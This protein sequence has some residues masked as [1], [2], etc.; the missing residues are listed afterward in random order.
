[1]QK[2]AFASLIAALGLTLAVAVGPA[3]AQTPTGDAYGGLGGQTEGPADS[4]P[5]DSGPADVAPTDVAP[6]TETAAETE[7]GGEVV[8]VA[9]TS[10]DDSGS[11][12]FTGFEVSIAALIGLGLLGT[13]F[14]LRR[15]TRAHEA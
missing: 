3:Q 15:T 10:N 7:E 2:K 4:G 6:T 8:P 13:G 11:L 14:M 9:T 5:T 1:V 12:P